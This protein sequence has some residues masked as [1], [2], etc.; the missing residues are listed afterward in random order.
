MI[1]YTIEDSAQIIQI[2][3]FFHTSQNPTKWKK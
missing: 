3:G 1:H 2:R